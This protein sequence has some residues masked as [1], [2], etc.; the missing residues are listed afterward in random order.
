MSDWIPYF[1]IFYIVNSNCNPSCLSRHTLRLPATFTNLTHPQ[2]PPQAGA[3]VAAE[4]LQQSENQR[5]IKSSWQTSSIS[6]VEALK[7]HLH[8][9]PLRDM[10]HTGQG[11]PLRMLYPI[12]LWCDDI[13]SNMEVY[14]Q[15]L[16]D[17]TAHFEVM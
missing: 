8:S 17:H 16:G 1:F 14:I 9:A 11:V 13:Y 5:Y 4:R 12:R 2:P 6:L 10:E 15:I 7:A 3:L